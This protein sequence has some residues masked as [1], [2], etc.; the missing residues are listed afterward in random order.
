MRIRRFVGLPFRLRDAALVAVCALAACGGGGTTVEAITQTEAE[1]IRD[2]CVADGLRLLQQLA[3]R[4]APLARAR[5]VEELEAT[6]L[7][8][9]CTF[10]AR[11]DGYYLSCPTI[12]LD[13]GLEFERDGLPVNDPALADRVALRLGGDPRVSGEI[14]MEQ[15][16]ARGMV[17][18]GGFERVSD[19]GCVAHLDFTQLAGLE[20]FGLPDGALG[21]F[22]TEGSVDVRVAMPGGDAL[23]HGS[24]AL[25]GRS[26]VLALNFD[27]LALLDELA[28]D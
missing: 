23:A 10:R 7:A 8:L 25:R 6:A 18:H 19:L 14:L 11:P 21:L 1:E 3:D 4:I 13:L 9:G 15:D 16:P 27:G 12:G 17:M 24:A 22:F 5:D 2:D 26:A 28:L 20:A